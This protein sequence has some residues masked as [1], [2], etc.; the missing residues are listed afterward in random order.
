MLVATL[1]PKTLAMFQEVNTNITG[2]E[3][4][5]WIKRPLHNSDSKTPLNISIYKSTSFAWLQVE[6]REGLTWKII[7]MSC[8][9]LLNI[10][11][12]LDLALE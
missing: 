8:E 4:L 2:F 11:L 10:A 9:I 3:S 1:N 5:Q 7:Y 12:S 6:L